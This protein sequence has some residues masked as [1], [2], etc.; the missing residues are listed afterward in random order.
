MYVSFSL[1]FIFPRKFLVLWFYLGVHVV[2]ISKVDRR[3]TPG[4]V[5]FV[6]GKIREPVGL[7]V[8]DWGWGRFAGRV[9]SR[10]HRRRW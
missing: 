9:G 4:V 7:F 1:I 2:L 8:G 6:L 5:L 3:S 10:R